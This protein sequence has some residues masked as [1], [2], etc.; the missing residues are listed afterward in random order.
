MLMYFIETASHID[1]SSFWVY[2]L[3]YDSKGHIV[4]LTTCYHGHLT[5]EKY[6]CQL[7]QFFVVPTKQRRGL[8]KLMM[9]AVIAHY[10]DDKHCFELIV[11]FPNESFQKVHDIINVERLMG[12][13]AEFKKALAVP[14]LNDVEAV[15]K[16]LE[17]SKNAANI[18][19]TAKA[20]KIPAMQVQRLYS[21]AIFAKMEP[22]FIKPDLHRV[23]R[24]AM[25]RIL[26]IR[27]FRDFPDKFEGKQ[28]ILLKKRDAKNYCQTVGYT[29]NCE[30]PEEELGLSQLPKTQTGEFTKD[31]AMKEMLAAEAIKQH[32]SEL[33]DAMTEDFR[34]IREKV[35]GILK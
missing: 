31:G 13:D 8:G 4:G 25:K 19:K 17:F 14:T 27:G 21:L 22:S 2:Y 11:E 9:E 5:A 26:Y 15:Q 32:L 24:L 29:W 23:F 7:G 16:A 6:R 28:E 18:A 34:L 20:L 1:V 35:R 12:A 3:L 10:D 30:A 33:Y